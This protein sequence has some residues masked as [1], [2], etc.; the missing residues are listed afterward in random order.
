M[1][2]LRS[3]DIKGAIKDHLCRGLTKDSAAALNLVDEGNL[4]RALKKINDLVGE[5]EKIKEIDLANFKITKMTR[6]DRSQINKPMADG[7]EPALATNPLVS[8]RSER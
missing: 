7:A 5:I 4:K 1:A 2:K 8:P 3:E 6:S